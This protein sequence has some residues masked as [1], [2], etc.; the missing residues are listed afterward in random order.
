MS[1]KNNK[2]K[3]KRKNLLTNILAGFL[4][5]L[6]LA[7]IFNAQIRDMFMVWNTNKYQVSHLMTQR[8]RLLTCAGFAQF[9]FELTNL[10]FQI[11][12]AHV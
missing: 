6:S 10:F 1:Q 5:V 7:L 8:Q 3:N 11:G 12:R 2:K 4:I 9:I